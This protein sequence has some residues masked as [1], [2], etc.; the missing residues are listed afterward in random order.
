VSVDLPNAIASIEATARWYGVGLA[1][2]EQKRAI[3]QI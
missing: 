2:H 1:S 3:R